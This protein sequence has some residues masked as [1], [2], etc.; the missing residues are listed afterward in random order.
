MKNSTFV[1][2]VAIIAIAG[3]IIAAL[4]PGLASIPS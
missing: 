2:I 4:L 3:I 1:R